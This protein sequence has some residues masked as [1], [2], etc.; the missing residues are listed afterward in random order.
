MC[1]FLN[2]KFGLKDVFFIYGMNWKFGSGKFGGWK[3]EVVS[4][5]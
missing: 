4:E 1:L 3:W 2:M 5:S